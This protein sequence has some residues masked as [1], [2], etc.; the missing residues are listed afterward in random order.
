[1]RRNW[2]LRSPSSELVRLSSRGKSNTE[3]ARTRA[4]Y[5]G[6]LPNPD[7]SFDLLFG[8]MNRNFEEHLYVPIG[9]DNTFEPAPIDRGQ[10]T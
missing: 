3:A 1:M 9:P 8:Y 5:E 2:R 10:P 4:A 6:Y 7:G